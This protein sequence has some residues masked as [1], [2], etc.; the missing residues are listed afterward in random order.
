MTFSVS[1]IVVCETTQKVVALDWAYENDDGR[2]SNQWRLLEPYGEEPL[3]SCTEAVLVKW[4][5]EQLPN[6]AAQLDAQISAAKAQH[7]L[8]QSL[9][10]YDAHVD[11][12]PTPITQEI[13]VPDLPEA[14]EVPEV[15][16]T[17][18]KKK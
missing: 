4:L 11:G 15:K 10:G 2:L 3:A 17:K 5:T 13:D 7:E 9:R 8:E 12:P 18:A 14:P 1:Q 16:K 6:T